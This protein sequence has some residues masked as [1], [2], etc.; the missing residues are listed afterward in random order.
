MNSDEEPVSEG[1]KKGYTEILALTR[2]I[3]LMSL[4]RELVFRHGGTGLIA[5]IIEADGIFK[6]DEFDRFRPATESEKAEAL[7]ALADLHTWARRRIYEVFPSPPSAAMIVDYPHPERLRVFGW[8]DR[9]AIHAALEQSAGLAADTEPSDDTKAAEDQ[10]TA[11]R[12]AAIV[13]F[14]SSCIGKRQKNYIQKAVERF[15]LAN[16]TIR[17]IWREGRPDAEPRHNKGGRPKI[18]ISP[19]QPA[20]KQP[21]KTTRY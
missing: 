19:F 3:S 16:S 18:P 2:R 20:F 6:V 13:A 14:I 9:A 1:D 17:K 7:Q 10:D 21:K 11:E 15:Q 5:S 12:N 8:P 4:A